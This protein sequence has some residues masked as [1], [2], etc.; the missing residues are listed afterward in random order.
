MYPSLPLP[1]QY[2]PQPVPG[3]AHLML[4]LQFNGLLGVLLLLHPQ[5]L[6]LVAQ[7]IGQGGGRAVENRTAWST[8]ISA[9]LS[10]VWGTPYSSTRTQGPSYVSYATLPKDQ[11]SPPLCTWPLRAFAKQS[12]HS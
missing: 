8:R 1:S 9:T 10:Q 4:F 3:T 12:G 7:Q 2:P 6:V 5:L 11:G